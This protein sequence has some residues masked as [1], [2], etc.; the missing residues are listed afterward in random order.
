MTRLGVF[1]SI[2][3]IFMATNISFG[4]DVQQVRRYPFY[5]DV[6]EYSAEVAKRLESI[7]YD[8]IDVSMIRVI[9]NPKSFDNRSI[10]VSGVFTAGERGLAIYFDRES[11][12]YHRVDNAISISLG[13]SHIKPEMMPKIEG[14]YVEVVGIYKAET[15]TDRFYVNGELHEVL[16][17]LPSAVKLKERDA[18]NVYTP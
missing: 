8:A 5:F 4:S 6:S 2:A 15:A 7:W 3:V 17:I 16:P 14:H 12:E 10:R 9:A 11:Y 1:I 18:A 13:D